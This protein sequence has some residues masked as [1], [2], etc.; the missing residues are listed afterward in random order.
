MIRLSSGS[1]RYVNFF[2]KDQS[3]DRIEFGTSNF[4]FESDN[5]SFATVPVPEP[6][7][8][9]LVAGALAAMFFMRRRRTARAQ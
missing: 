3:Y 5:H 9:T 6:S 2:L 8:I 1:N 4:A 7:M